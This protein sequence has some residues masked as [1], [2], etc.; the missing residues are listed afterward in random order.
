[1][2]KGKLIN[3]IIIS[4]DIILL[5]VVLFLL[6]RYGKLKDENLIKGI[7]ASVEADDGDSLY[8]LF[9]RRYTAALQDE[10]DAD[11]KEL[12]DLLKEG[13][14]DY[15]ADDIIDDVGEIRD[16]SYEISSR[17]KYSGDELV[18]AQ[19]NMED[20]YGIK[21]KAAQE[22]IVTWNVTGDNGTKSYEMVVWLYKR[23]LK[24]Y[25]LDFDF[26]V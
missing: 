24:W 23:G 16:I 12:V 1:V 25:L 8:Y 14:I 18:E 19:T 7:T 17:R 9:D 3:I 11:R 10:Y 4:I 6:L 13:Y 15:V 21:L 20:E 22:V 2:K 26:N 5:A